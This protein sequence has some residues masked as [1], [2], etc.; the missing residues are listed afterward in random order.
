MH[1]ACSHSLPS[2]QEAATSLAF[3][4]LLMPLIDL[5]KG[6]VKAEVAAKAVRAWPGSRAGGEGLWGGTSIC[7]VILQPAGCPVPV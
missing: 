2:M 4:K 7:A 5:G 6:I 3:F 1:V